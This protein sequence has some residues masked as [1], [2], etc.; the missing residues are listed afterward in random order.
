VRTE[1]IVEAFLVRQGRCRAA[2]LSFYFR[3][4]RARS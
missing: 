2:K 4:A 1:D 3:H